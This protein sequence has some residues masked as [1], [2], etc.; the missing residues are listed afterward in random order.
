MVADEYIGLQVFSTRNSLHV[1]RWKM[2]YSSEIPVS[3]TDTVQI[4]QTARD[5]NQLSRDL[6]EYT[7]V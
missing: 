5:A 7:E 3:Y 2:A 4:L 1:V 6:G